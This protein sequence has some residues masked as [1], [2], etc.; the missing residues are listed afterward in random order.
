M[1]IKHLDTN[2]LK[3]YSTGRNIFN[4][5]IINKLTTPIEYT[6]KGGLL[7]E[8][9]FK[10][11]EI[12]MLPF[13]KIFSVWLVILFRKSVLWGLLTFILSILKLHS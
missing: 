7:Y 6:L 12:C 11:I 9:Y 8:F 4:Y 3:L 10:I 1:N 2:I 13:Y 5:T